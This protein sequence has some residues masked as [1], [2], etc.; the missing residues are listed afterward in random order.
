MKS[1]CETVLKDRGVSRRTFQQKW[2]KELQE[3]ADQNIPL[4]DPRVKAAFETR[5]TSQKVA[6]LSNINGDT[7][8][9]QDQ[10]MVRTPPNRHL[11][12]ESDSIFNLE[13]EKIWQG[14]INQY[15]LWGNHLCADDIMGVMNETLREDLGEDCQPVSRK[16]VG[17]VYR[18]ANI[19]AERNVNSIDTARIEQTGDP[20]TLETFNTQL[21]NDFYL[22]NA[23]FPDK[24]PA[25]KAD[26]TPDREYNADEIGLN[27]TRNR[28]PRLVPKH[29][30]SQYRTYKAS[31]E[32]DGKMNIHYTVMNAVRADGAK[33]VPAEGVEGAPPDFVIIQD[34]DYKDPAEGMSTAERNAA[35][36]L[37]RATDDVSVSARLLHGF[38]EKFQR[39]MRPVEMNPKGIEVHGSKTGS[40]TKEIIFDWG[41]HLLKNLPHDQGPNGQG[42][43][44]NLDFHGS[45]LNPKFQWYMLTNGVFVNHGPS[46][47]STCGQACDLGSNLCM[48]QSIATVAEE[49]ARLSYESNSMLLNNLNI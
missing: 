25:Q 47:T 11:S 26:L 29:M 35:L 23:I 44:L 21:D 15:A 38:Y 42:V 5:F 3:Y 34:S 22:L 13:E 14:V 20:Q 27:P 1:Y 2:P 30:R 18:A 12:A 31:R 37:E 10:S 40:M 46:H 32:G 8:A 9:V 6:I 49:N 7:V 4:D 43:L 28:K 45:R 19:E 16:T 48:H 24:F 33:C 36:L 17:R 39:G 41:C